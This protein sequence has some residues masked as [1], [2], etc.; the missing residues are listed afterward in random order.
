MDI[1]ERLKLSYKEWYKKE[2]ST[3]LTMEQK[4]SMMKRVTELRRKNLVCT[5]QGRNYID[6]FPEL[7]PY[8]KK[9]R[10]TG[11]QLCA[12]MEAIFEELHFPA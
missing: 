10:I 9:G 1:I 6:Q 12:I 4:L 11:L 7:K 8:S 2:M 5:D 3:K